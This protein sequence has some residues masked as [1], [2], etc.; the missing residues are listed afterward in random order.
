M[1]KAASLSVRSVSLLLMAFA[2]LLLASTS[3][4]AAQ[5]TESDTVRCL[6]DGRFA[7]EVAWKD[8]D[9]QEGAGHVVDTGQVDS[10]DSALFWFFTET[11]WELLVKI[12][13]GCNL[14]ERFWV[15]SAATT[16][17]EYTLTIT[18]TEADETRTWKNP[19]GQRSDAVTDTAA[20]ATCP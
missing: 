11:N 16:D 13:D 8:P 18:D 6:Q 2:G 10:D 14:N 4:A 15:F 9:A 12:L 20:F 19:L 1:R 5:C 7:V 17:V 3:S